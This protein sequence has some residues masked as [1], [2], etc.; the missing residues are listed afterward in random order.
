[1]IYIIG[2]IIGTALVTLKPDNQQQV[3]FDRD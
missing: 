3:I 2:V 1:M